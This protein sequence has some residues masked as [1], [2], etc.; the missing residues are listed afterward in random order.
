MNLTH[1]GKIG[2]LPK[3]LRDQVNR[4]L[5]NGEKGRSIVAWLNSLPEV[6][7][8]LAA[9]FEG[10]P[11]REQNLSEWRKRGYR[12]WLLRREAQA[13]AAEIGHLPAADSPLTDQ[14]AAWGSVRYLIA[15]RQLVE[16]KASSPCSG[17]SGERRQ[18][19]ASPSTN[20]P[21]PCRARRQ[22]CSPSNNT[23]RSNRDPESNLQILRHFCRD[24]AALRRGD[25]TSAR[26]KL[27][28][29]RL[30]FQSRVNAC[31]LHRLMENQE[32]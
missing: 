15:V 8:I 9:H 21:R 12:Q 32:P 4:R 6:Q 20:L 27:D 13:M 5:E 16:N 1:Q 24:I 19:A 14:L 11:V 26:L 31:G 22:E 3:T 10:K 17:V 7:A 18:L 25:H 30:E 28:Q 23:G 29:A 2:R